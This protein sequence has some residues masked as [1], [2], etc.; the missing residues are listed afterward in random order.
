MQVSTQ[1]TSRDVPEGSDGETPLIATTTVAT[2]EE[3]AR[4]GRLL[5]EERLA[6]CV[7]LVPARSIYRWEGAISDERETLL[8]IKTV[9]RNL[10]RLQARL[11]EIHPYQLPEWVVQTPEEVSKAYGLWIVE[12]V[13]AEPHHR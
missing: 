6:A 10:A 11:H 3:G 5:V 7:T 12:S 1:R 9:R 4:I 2:E 8:I 13:R